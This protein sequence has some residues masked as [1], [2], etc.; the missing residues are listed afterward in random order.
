M[1]RQRLLEALS[2]VQRL[3]SNLVRERAHA[4]RE[5]WRWT[6]AGEG[7]GLNPR[8]GRAPQSL[9]FG[10]REG[11]APQAWEGERLGEALSKPAQAADLQRDYR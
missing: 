9:S 6:P 4:F 2:R 8:R 3:I 11:P 7:P 1:A 5:G 10:E